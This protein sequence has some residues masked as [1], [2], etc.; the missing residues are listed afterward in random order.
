MQFSNILLAVFASVVIAAPLEQEEQA[1]RPKLYLEGPSKETPQP[2]PA[3]PMPA[4]PTNDCVAC[5]KYCKDPSNGIALG[6][7]C[8]VVKCGIECLIG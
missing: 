5:A 6:A 1:D 4:A 7:A 8:L 3:K 2:T